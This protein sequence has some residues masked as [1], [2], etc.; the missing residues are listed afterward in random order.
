[1]SLSKAHSGRRLKATA[2]PPQN[3]STRRRASWPVHK[4]RRCGTNQRFPPAHFRGGRSA[5]FMKPLGENW[6]SLN[7]V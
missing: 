1:M 6:P 5:L 4:G 3:G 2:N 7:Y